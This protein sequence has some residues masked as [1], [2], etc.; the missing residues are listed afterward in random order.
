MGRLLKAGDPVKGYIDVFTTLDGD[1]ILLER[2]VLN[3]VVGSGCW[4]LSI[5]VLPADMLRGRTQ[6][7]HA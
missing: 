7:W 4:V 5:E 3:G 1:K 2:S 6:L